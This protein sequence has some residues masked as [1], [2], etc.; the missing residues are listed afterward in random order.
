MTDWIAADYPYKA[1]F[2]KGTSGG[3]KNK[4]E[5]IC[6][7]DPGVSTAAGLWRIRKFVYDSTGFHTQVL[8]ANGE[9]KFNKIQTSYSSY[10]YSA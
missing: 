6:E 10:T 2:I 7:A 5:Y 1:I 3:A 4:I 9:R 8:W